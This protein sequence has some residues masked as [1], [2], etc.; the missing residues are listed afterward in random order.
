VPVRERHRD[1]RRVGVWRTPLVPGRHI[2]GLVA[3]HSPGLFLI[4]VSCERLLAV[5]LWLLF[6]R[7][8]GSI[9]EPVGKVEVLGLGPAAGAVVG[10]G[11][12]SDVVTC[13]HVVPTITKV[14]PP[15]WRDEKETCT[16]VF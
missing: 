10:V 9:D 1:E 5:R 6:A 13:D 15:T 4:G 2:L 16:C 11:C 14:L 7:H 12:Y 8:D 3:V